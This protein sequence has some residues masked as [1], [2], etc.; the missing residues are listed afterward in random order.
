MLEI[1]ICLK[2]HRFAT[3]ISGRTEAALF[4]NKIT[5]GNVLARYKHKCDAK[6][7]LEPVDLNAKSKCK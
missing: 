3:F 1:N 2:T 4:I 6:K 5:N 7:N